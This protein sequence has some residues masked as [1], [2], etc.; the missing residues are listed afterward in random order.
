MSLVGSTQDVFLSTLD[1]QSPVTA[2]PVGRL[3]AS[4]NAVVRRYENPRA[5]D[6]TVTHVSVEKRN[7]YTTNTNV[8][9][10]NDGFFATPP[11][12]NADPQVLFGGGD[13]L[14]L[15]SGN[16]LYTKSKTWV[17]ASNQTDGDAIVLPQTV[18]TTDLYAA[19]STCDA[20]DMAVI[21]D[22][23]CTAW[24]EN[25]TQDANNSSSLA[26]SSLTAT[27]FDGVRIMFRDQTDDSPIRAAFTFDP[28][29]IFDAGLTG[30]FSPNGYQKVRVL[31]QGG[32]FWV[33]QDYI[34]GGGVTRIM[35]T[36]FGPTGAL[37]ASTH[38]DTPIN[39]ASWDSAVIAGQGIVIA[40]PNNGV[41]VKFVSFNYSSG[42]ASTTNTDTTLLNS[43]NV[44]AWLTDAAATSL[45]GYLVTVDGSAGSQKLWAYRVVSL[46]Q[47]H[48]YPQVNSLFLISST[49]TYVSGITGY[50]VPGTTGLVV[51]FTTMDLTGAPDS[52]TYSAG[53]NG[54]NASASNN[55]PDQ[56]NNTTWC[57]AVPFT[58]A[59]T[60]A[61][62][63]KALSLVSRAFAVGGDYVAVAYYPA[64]KLSPLE[65]FAAN[66]DHYPVRPINPSNFQ[67]TWYVIP[68]ASKQPIAGR[69]EYGLAAAD[70]QVM[71]I[72]VDEGVI[73]PTPRNRCLT[74]VSVTV[75]GALTLPLC[76]RGDQNIP[77]AG[78]FSNV[79]SGTN[80][81]SAPSGAFGVSAFNSALT[82]GRQVAPSAAFRPVA[83]AS[84]PATQAAYQ[85][86]NTVGVREFR[87]GPDCGQAFSV[88][89][90]T[91]VPGMMAA[92]VEPGDT[93]ITEHGLISS[94]CPR[95]KV[96]AA[97][98]ASPPVG[99]LFYRILPEWTSG[100]GKTYQ[101]LPSAA[102]G[103]TVKAGDNKAFDV[104]SPPLS[105][106]NKRNIRLSIYRTGIVQAA[107]LG[108]APVTS[109]PTVN[110]PATSALPTTGYYKITNDLTPRYN[111]FDPT[112]RAAFS[113]NY[114]DYLQ[115]Y[116]QG[117]GEQLYTDLG[118]LP[119]FP[120]PAFRAGCVWQNRAW[121]IGYDNALWF[122]GE[123]TE[124]HG[125]WFNPGFRVVVP[126]T[127]EVV[128][129]APMENVL[130]V[131]CAE[132]IWYIPLGQA[133]P[134][135]DGS[136][137]VPT[138]IRLP[139]EMGGT[140]F[141]SVVRQGCLYSSSAG[142]VWLIT[143][144]LDNQWIGQRAQDDLAPEILD[145]VEAGN[146]VIAYPASS[147]NYLMA[148][149]T[150]LGG[151]SKWIMPSQ[152]GKLAAR[153]G[154]SVYADSTRVWEQT[155]DTWFDNDTVNGV[156]YYVPMCTTVAPI[157]IGGVRSWKRTWA[158]Q[159]EGMVYDPCGLT[160]GLAYTDT[161]AIDVTYETKQ[162]AAGELEAEY[163]P[164]KQLESSIGLEVCDS[165]PTLTKI[166]TIVPNTVVPFVDG[167]W[168]STAKTWQT[169]VT[170]T[171]TLFAQSDWSE[172]DLWIRF[173]NQLV[174]F[175]WTVVGSSNATVA[176]MDGV[177]RV[178][179]YVDWGSF[180]VNGRRGWVVLQNGGGAQLLMWM[181]GLIANDYANVRFNYSPD[182]GYTGGAAPSTLPTAP[183]SINIDNGTSAMLGQSPD[184]TA[185]IYLN[186]TCSVDVTC[187]RVVVCAAGILYNFWAWDQVR[188]QEAGW[189]TRN[190]S[191]TDIG[192][193]NRAAP[194]HTMVDASHWHG[195]SGFVTPLIASRGPAGFAV[196][197]MSGYSGD[198]ANA[199]DDVYV[200]P[201][202]SAVS[203]K[204]LAPSIPT[205]RNVG[206]GGGAGGQ[207]GQFGTMT[208]MWLIPRSFALGNLTTYPGGFAAFYNIL[209]PWPS[210]TPPRL[211]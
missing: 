173:A 4:Q 203:G 81:S 124:G 105:P 181:D 13:A 160:V 75:N 158:L 22:V 24:R 132:S 137:T 2:K 70:W 171:N 174:A 40:M 148:Y 162:I 94:E 206:S 14:R 126:T 29:G 202:T 138:P 145:M 45:T 8:V 47:N 99:A 177:M 154:A 65:Q 114:Q 150:N 32:L 59:S 1:Q 115:A 183:H 3:S 39:G 79:A 46:A 164:T 25:A 11:A 96:S 23:A 85:T 172:A 89:Q 185:H 180:A 199:T 197:A 7:G 211:T 38:A 33:L 121:L 140:G 100:T 159:I 127:E 48:L 111:Q 144:A 101:A 188:N 153:N 63:R 67:P 108:G 184:A 136:G 194:G 118:A 179:T 50:T 49:V 198:V 187:T 103:F 16:R 200:L 26:D 36:V 82:G 80:P 19:N 73:A 128:A 207:N 56:M 44:C 134:G 112:T 186:M 78:A 68:L 53:A 34:L 97:S 102:F 52:T 95:V 168:P 191:I 157:H 195:S 5:A 86:A 169:P 91:Y 109:P 87:F 123:I 170:I 6:G 116:T 131:F 69:L 117:T 66:V 125:E 113:G 9:L 61:N 10:D 201:A 107:V 155:P 189:P 130:L 139:F 122:S 149:D 146:Y 62:E 204:P 178:L 77:E 41:G 205:L 190:Y 182:G 27:P 37:I 192:G 83:Q 176:A 60:L 196:F 71:A 17:K 133:L 30:S 20:P 98:S 161:G 135:N 35:V 163:R 147:S 15:I 84:P 110:T 208:D 28:A 167:A 143:R 64:C 166:A 156:T 129:I 57:Y 152:I 120:A 42:F 104:S 210:I 12:L 51:A 54:S 31:A 193:N 55:F 165:A 74:A 92:I 76:F 90:A 209:I 18:R 72:Y 21:G 175:G 43:M 88:G 142:G 119:K 141:T 58:G 151:W 106:T 93:T